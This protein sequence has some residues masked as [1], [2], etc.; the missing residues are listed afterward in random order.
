MSHIIMRFAAL[1]VLLA[2]RAE[3]ISESARRYNEPSADRRT[4]CGSHGTLIAVVVCVRSTALVAAPAARTSAAAVRPCL[5]Q[6]LCNDHR[7]IWVGIACLDHPVIVE[8]TGGAPARQTHCNE[9]RPSSLDGQQWLA[10]SLPIAGVLLEGEHIAET[11]S[12]THSWS[13]PSSSAGAMCRYEST[14]WVE[15]SH[16]LEAI[17]RI[18]HLHNYASSVSRFSGFRS[19]CTEDLYTL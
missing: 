12:W 11:G 15:C 4:H 17:L 1:S 5:V 16:Q 7:D 9:L 8:A 3:C 18:S 6:K 2:C 14:M 10:H 19:V 13:W